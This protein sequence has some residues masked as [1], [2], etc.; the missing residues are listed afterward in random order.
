MAVDPLARME[1]G[2]RLTTWVWILGVVVTVVGVGM[3]VGGAVEGK[4]R[5][6]VEQVLF[7]GWTLGPPAWFVLQ[8]YLWPAPPAGQDRFRT[9]QAI[10][11][12]IWAGI[13]AFLAAII[14][15][16]WG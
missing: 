16:R 10:V 4:N 1:Q 15:G 9:Y 8:H 2:V 14:F 6:R 5:V 7:A 13:A 3:L 11:R 12:A